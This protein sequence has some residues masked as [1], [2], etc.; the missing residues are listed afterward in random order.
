MS[1]IREKAPPAAAGQ[2]K[3]GVGHLGEVIQVIDALAN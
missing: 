2:Q 3:A 1:V